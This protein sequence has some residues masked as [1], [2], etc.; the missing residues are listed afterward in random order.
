MTVRRLGSLWHGASAWFQLYQLTPTGIVLV[1]RIPRPSQ[2]R[3]EAQVGSIAQTRI[4]P[5]GDL[6]G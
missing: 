4:R 3:W 5:I 6:C 2:E 1:E